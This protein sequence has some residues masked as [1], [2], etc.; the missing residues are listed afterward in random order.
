MHSHTEERR[1]VH[2]CRTERTAGLAHAG[3]R[4]IE[5]E[6][7]EACKAGGGWHT[8]GGPA[9]TGINKQEDGGYW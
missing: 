6:A 9:G 4:R 1:L 7:G 5:E 2:C 3:G 8:Q